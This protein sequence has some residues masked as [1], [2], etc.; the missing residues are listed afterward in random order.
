MVAVL[1]LLLLVP[2][3]KQPPCPIVG[4]WEIEWG[5][6]RQTTWFATDGTCDSCRF[7]TG[8]WSVTIDGDDVTVWFSEQGDRSHYAAAFDRRTGIGAGY[9]V[10]GERGVW[11]CEVK[12]RKVGKTERKP[13]E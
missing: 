2:L 7:G 8:V 11:V 3:P 4:E 13:K 6:C 1:V 10:S 9:S 12:V 5:A